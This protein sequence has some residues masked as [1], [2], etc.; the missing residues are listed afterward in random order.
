MTS[1]L[2]AAA[3]GLALGCTAEPA[4]PDRPEAD[5]AADRGADRASDAAKDQAIADAAL[6]VDQSNWFTASSATRKDWA[7]VQS[8]FSAMVPMAR[9]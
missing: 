7:N 9:Q 5:G 3:V 4:S 8:T 6:P 1:R 2:L